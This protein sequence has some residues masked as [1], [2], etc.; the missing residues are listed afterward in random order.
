MLL[1]AVL[2]SLRSDE[3]QQ[4][5]HLWRTVLAKKTYQR[6]RYQKQTRPGYGLGNFKVRSMP[7]AVWTGERLHNDPSGVPVILVLGSRIPLM[8]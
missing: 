6:L 8:F 1:H 5:S 7:L 4:G 2:F 3:E